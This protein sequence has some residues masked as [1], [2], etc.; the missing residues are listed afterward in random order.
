MILRNGAITFVDVK[1]PDVSE[2][3]ALTQFKLWRFHLVLQGT[4]MSWTPSGKSEFV[5]S[6]FESI[7]T[8]QVKFSLWEIQIKQGNLVHLKCENP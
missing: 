4:Y 1:E 6:T 2:I 3:K 8:F 5:A 7:K